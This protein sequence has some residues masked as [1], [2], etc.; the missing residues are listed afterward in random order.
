MQVQ[1]TLFTHSG[2][3]GRISVNDNNSSSHP[4][5]VKENRYGSTIDY[6]A[7]LNLSLYMPTTNADGNEE[8]T[9][10]FFTLSFF[11]MYNFKTKLEQLLLM[12]SSDFYEEKEHIDRGLILS[13]KDEYKLPIIITNSTKKNQLGFL[14]IITYNKRNDEYVPKVKVLINRDDI[15]INLP[16]E[17][18]QAIAYNLS[19][20]DLHSYAMNLINT[21]YANNAY[22]AKVI[23]QSQQSVTL[24]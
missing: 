8:R 20:L 18:I 5:F 11:D 14:P 9:S 7:Y 23:K 12:L 13:I 1:Q 19:Q 6:S 4:K 21:I 2:F 10:E 24:T 15:G 3:T 17:R 22:N 16:V